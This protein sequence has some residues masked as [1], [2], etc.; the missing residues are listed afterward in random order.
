MHAKCLIK[1]SL[2]GHKGLE[3][4]PSFCNG[5]GTIY[6]HPLE[7]GPFDLTTRVWIRSLGMLL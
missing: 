1:C 2:C 4:L 6:I 5:L 7:E 3:S